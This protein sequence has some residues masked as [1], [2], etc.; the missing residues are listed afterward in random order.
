MAN[1][2]KG[3]S[4]AAWTA[5][6]GLTP[7]YVF[8]SSL[9]IGMSLGWAFLLVYAASSAMALLLPAAMGR[10]RI[11]IFALI[12]SSVACSISASFIRIIDPFLFES[13]YRRLFLVAFTVPVL[14]SALMPETIADRER[15]WE[16]MVRGLGY[17][18]TIVV[19]GALRE[20]M[21]SGSISIIA[22]HVTTSLLPMMAQ[23]AGAMVLLALSMAGFRLALT[24]ARGAGR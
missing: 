19:F 13:T 15:A 23:P 24:L 22:E 16:N 6:A 5:F 9:S 7:L 1:E 17:A 12:A 18:A 14:K 8:S 10:N 21:A 11:F 2:D 3:G 20:F 4:V